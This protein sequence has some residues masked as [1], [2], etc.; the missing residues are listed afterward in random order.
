MNN[1]KICSVCE[2]GRIDYLLDKTS[3][4]CSHISCLKDGKCG[5]YKPLADACELK[6]CYVFK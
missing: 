5:M 4:F 3:V 6:K 2:T 1:K